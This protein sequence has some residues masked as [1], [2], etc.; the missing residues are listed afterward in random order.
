MTDTT[1]N[2][3]ENIRA[4]IE[5]DIDDIDIAMEV[6]GKYLSNSLDENDDF[7]PVLDKLEAYKTGLIASLN[8]ISDDPSN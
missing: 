1:V 2:K 5:C 7:Y 3:L 6:I 8:H 4:S